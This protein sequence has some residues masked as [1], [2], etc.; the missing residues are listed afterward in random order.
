MDCSRE[1]LN[2]KWKEFQ[3]NTLSFKVRRVSFLW[4]ATKMPGPLLLTYW[5]HQKELNCCTNT[6]KID[7]SF[8]CELFMLSRC[9]TQFLLKCKELYGETDTHTHHYTHH[10]NKYALPIKYFIVIQIRITKS[11]KIRNLMKDQSGSHL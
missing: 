2:N 6:K 10:I 9:I 1:H 4:G 8:S 3:M 5:C 11:L 7:I